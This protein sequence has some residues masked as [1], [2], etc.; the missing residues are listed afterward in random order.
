MVDGQ[1]SILDKIITTQ[2]FSRKEQFRPQ[3]ILTEILKA[4]SER[5]AQVLM[6]R[7]GLPDKSKE[8]LESVGKSFQITRERVRQ[9]EKLVISKIKKS[10]KLQQALTPAKAIIIESIESE[11]GALTEQRLLQILSDAAGHDMPNNTIRLFLFELFSDVVKPIGYNDNEFRPA[12]LLHNTSLDFLKRLLQ[13][14]FTLLEQAGKPVSDESLATNIISTKALSP[15][16]LLL[17]D[18]KMVLSLL[19]TGLLIKRNPYGEWGLASWE[20]ITPKRMSDKIYLVLKKDGK[21][22]HFRTITQLINEQKFD[23]KHAHAPTVHNE[24][25]L[26]KRYVLVGRGIYAL[27]EWGYQPGVVAEVLV[28]IL[29]SASKAMSRTELLQELQKRRLVQTGTVYLALTNKK[30]FTRTDEGKYQLAQQT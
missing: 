18:S 9:I 6:R 4:L 25:I 2:Q 22:L 10:A 27:K 14:A 3:E 5:E 29:K 30:L 16:G 1:D 11:G 20:T 12:W 15:L 26:D 23:H 13:L 17:T 24:L 19:E 28:D 7:F 21:P 8:T